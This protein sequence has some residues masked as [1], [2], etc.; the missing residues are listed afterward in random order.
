MPAPGQWTRGALSVAAIAVAACGTDS[1][2][3]SGGGAGGGSEPSESLGVSC[4]LPQDQLFDGGVA[5]DAIPALVNPELV[6]PDDEGTEYLS[7]YAAFSRGILELP[8][9]RVVGL[10]VGDQAVAVP[11]NILWWHE[12]VHFDLGGQRLAVTYCPLTGSALVFDASEARTVRF[13][14][15]G[16]LFQNN[17]V[18]FDPESQSLWAAN[19]LGGPLRSAQRYPAGRGTAYRDELGELEDSPSGDTRSV[20]QHGLGA[21]LRP[22]PV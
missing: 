19:A 13:G 12:I 17:L 11:H 14:V 5:R 9:V 10:V 8:D 7:A 21:E 4:N 6:G 18:M 1:L 16:L 22:I 15:S 3:G 20:V 2:Y